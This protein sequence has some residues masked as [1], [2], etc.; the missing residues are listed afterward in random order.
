MKKS[1]AR[2]LFVLRIQ[3]ITPQDR[4]CLADL[5][6]CIAIIMVIIEWE[7]GRTRLVELIFINLLPL[8][9]ADYTIVINP[10]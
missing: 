9:G 5:R 1:C 2:Q 10:V 6:A 4:V 3:E 8:N 7:L